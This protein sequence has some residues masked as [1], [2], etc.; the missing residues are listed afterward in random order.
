MNIIFYI[1]WRK[2]YFIKLL[3][4]E[5]RKDTIEKLIKNMLNVGKKKEKVLLSKIPFFYV[6]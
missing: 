2:T 4:K 3:L 6:Q 5:K 1:I